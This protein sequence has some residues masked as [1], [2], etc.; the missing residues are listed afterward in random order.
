MEVDQRLAQEAT[1]NWDEIVGGEFRFDRRI[2]EAAA[3]RRVTPAALLVF[4]D[5]YMA[6][7]A[8]ERRVL[9]SQVF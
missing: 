4:W 2:E 7:G 6:A 9:T 3:L 5:R 8:I 1:R